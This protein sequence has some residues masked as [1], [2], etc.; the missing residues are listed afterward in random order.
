MIKRE[1]NNIVLVNGDIWTIFLDEK[2]HIKRTGVLRKGVLF[3]QNISLLPC[4]QIS[5]ERT[6]PHRVSVLLCVN[7]AQYRGYY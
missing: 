2:W 4:M 5:K 1:H 6:K 3:S 7:T